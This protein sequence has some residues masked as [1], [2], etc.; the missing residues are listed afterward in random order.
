MLF[1][2]S[3]FGISQPK[4]LLNYENVRM[5]SY[6]FVAYCDGLSKIERLTD[7]NGV[8]TFL[9]SKIGQNFK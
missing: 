9:L 3:Q 6:G 5:V 1:N 2:S 8:L 4:R 7:Y